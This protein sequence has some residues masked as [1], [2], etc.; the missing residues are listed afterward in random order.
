MKDTAEITRLLNAWSGG[1]RAAFDRLFPMLERELRRLAR[2]V[3]AG[4]GAPN[5]LQTT[6]LVNEAYLRL[7]DARTA[8]WNDRAHFLAC[9]AR[10]MRRI[11][12]DEARARSAGKRGGG[13]RAL[14][15][16]EAGEGPL[17]RSADLVAIDDALA[18]L[19]RLDARRAQVV[20]MKFFAGMTL[21][22]TAAALGVSAETVTRDWRL[23][24]MWLLRELSRG[25]ND[26]A[27][28]TRR[29]EGL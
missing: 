3:L 7:V 15:L 25:N 20:E 4:E 26:R 21:E 12:V 29:G 23:A 6:A 5:T 14:T 27:T 24:K 13:L 17:H 22:E 9:C 19:E 28:P 18:D 1:D 11:L 10:V 2:G 16:E 8:T